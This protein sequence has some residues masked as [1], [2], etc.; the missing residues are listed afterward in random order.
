MR[1]T[2]AHSLDDRDGRH[3]VQGLVQ[4][5]PELVLRLPVRDERARVDVA[6]IHLA[7]LAIDQDRRGARDRDAT[8][9]EDW[10]VHGFARGGREGERY[11]V[12]RAVEV[13]RGVAVVVAIAQGFL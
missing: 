5:N 7:R 8:Q 12:F 6:S 1:K 4:S 10:L 9:D 2:V 3:F 11:A 13:V